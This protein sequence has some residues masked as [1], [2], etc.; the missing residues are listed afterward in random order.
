VQQ[1]SYFNRSWTGD[2]GSGLLPEVFGMI[3]PVERWVVQAGAST[4]RSQVRSAPTGLG[5]CYWLEGLVQAIEAHGSLSW[6]DVRSAP[7]P[8][9]T[10]APGA[11]TN[12]TVS[13]VTSTSATLL[14]NA[15]GDDGY[16]GTA[17][18]YDIR[19]STANIT[20]ANFGSATQASGEPA[21]AA[22]GNSQA[23]TVNG[24]NPNTTYYFALKS[25]DEA[26]NVSPLSNVPNR[27]TSSAGGLPSPWQDRDI[28]SVGLAGSASYS[29]GTF[30]V[31]GSGADI[32]GTA[33]AFHFVHQS[34]TGDGEIRARVTAVQNT[35]PWAKAGV[36]IR[37]SFAANS[38]HGM[39]VLS[40]ANGLAFQRRTSTGGSST[41]TG[42]AAAVAPIW[43]RVARSGSTLT[44][45]S[46]TNGSSWT[47][48]GSD[49]ISMS[50]TVQI[51]LAV[52]AHNNA[53]LNTSTFDNVTVSA[54][55]SAVAVSFS[56]ATN[57]YASVNDAAALDIAGSALCMEAWVKV[58]ALPAAGSLSTIMAR[59]LGS[60][61]GYALL[62]GDN[63]RFQVRL[64]TTGNSW[65]QFD[66]GALT[67]TS[68]TWYHVAASYDGATV[69]IFRDGTQVTS[70]AQSGTLLA[71]ANKLYFGGKRYDWSNQH[72]LNGVIDEARLSRVARYTANFTAPTA[73]FSNDANTVGLWHF[74]ENTGG[75]SADSSGNALTATLNAATWTSGKF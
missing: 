44:A 31:S 3:A 62:I 5:D 52:T 50:N 20:S 34:L 28:G 67:W 15:P 56:G 69:R 33:D 7:P 40:P 53:A 43:V 51:G 27:T 24:L 16:T 23:F 47:T 6:V 22:A 1:A 10:N 60:S 58:N 21:P 2:E 32:W 35:D 4:L 29:S 17:A 41:N 45:Y 55:S 8:P 49:T 14:W 39:M 63:G 65:G 25:S 57:S 75:T 71:G 26:G 42:G 48:V 13:T 61:S 72:F 46:S 59:E 19:Y 36:M 68:G 73:P 12:L 30:T 9:D 11:V 66:S 18:S 54:S 74:N 70:G 64:G 37:E 38:K